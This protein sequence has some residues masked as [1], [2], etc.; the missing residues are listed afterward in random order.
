MLIN[1]AKTEEFLKLIGVINMDKISLEVGLNLVPIVDKKQG[2]LLIE[3][4]NDIRKTLDFPPVRI[5]D[6]LILDENEYRILIN[7][8]EKFRDQCKLTTD[9]QKENVETVFDH[10]RRTVESHIE[11]LK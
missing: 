6:N 5:L 9:F 3:R 10:L 2:G 7:G 8:E 1:E 4:I 11:E